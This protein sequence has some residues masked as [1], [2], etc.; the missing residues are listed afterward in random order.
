[1]FGEEL[2]R[3]RVAAA[4]TQEDLAHR[5]KIS[6]NYVS[7]LEL[8]EKSPTLETL[9]RICKAMNIRVSVLIA[10]WER[11]RTTQK[12]PATRRPHRP[13]IRLD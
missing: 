1:M 6:R 13:T 10:R 12:S 9:D 3:A 2:R 7:L 4:M 8:D 11:R 5:A